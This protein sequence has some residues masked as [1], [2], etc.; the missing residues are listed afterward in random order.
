MCFIPWYREFIFSSRR[1]CA[2]LSI[3][4]ENASFSTNYFLFFQNVESEEYWEKLVQESDPSKQQKD[5]LNYNVIIA[6]IKSKILAFK[7]QVMRC[8]FSD[9]HILTLPQGELGI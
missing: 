7:A 5:L 6:Q 2:L 8:K 9:V 1:K 4:K 3:I